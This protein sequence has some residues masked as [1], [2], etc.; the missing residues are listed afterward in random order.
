MRVASG[1][2][3][4]R[5]ARVAEN[6][7]R[8]SPVT[9]LPPRVLL[10]ETP[11][12]RVELIRLTFAHFGD[13]VKYVVDL[14]RNVLAIGGEMHVEAEQYLLENGSR[15]VD[16]WGANYYPTRGREDCI[17]YTSLINISPRRDNRSMEIQDPKLR[18]RVQEITFQLIGCGDEEEWPISTPT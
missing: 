13:M 9:E 12:S 17:E 7:E 10:L 11:I 16:L 2:K 1:L 8:Q 4:T 18:L 15:Q 3:R 14:K 6:L 5:S